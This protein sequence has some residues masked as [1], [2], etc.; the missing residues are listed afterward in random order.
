MLSVLSQVFAVWDILTMGRVE[1]NSMQC[2]LLGI[3][4]PIEVDESEVFHV[5]VDLDRGEMPGPSTTRKVPS[6]RHLRFG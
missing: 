2:G 3:P 4:L 5:S 6:G 1:E